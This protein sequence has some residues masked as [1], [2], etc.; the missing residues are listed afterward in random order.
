LEGFVIY[1]LSLKIRGVTFMASGI[2][3][4]ALFDLVS[5]LTDERSFFAFVKALREDRIAKNVVEMKNPSNPY[6][7]MGWENDTIEAFLDA[8]VAWGGSTSQ[9]TAYY[10]VA[11]NPWQRVAQI[12]YAGTFYE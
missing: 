3:D 6:S 1:Q 12:L 9:G 7:P 10:A 4:G 11:V 5:E 2:S 8:A